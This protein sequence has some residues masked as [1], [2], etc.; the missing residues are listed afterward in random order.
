MS[1]SGPPMGVRRMFEF[2]RELRRPVRRRRAF[3]VKDGLYRRRRRSARAARP[4]NAARRGQGRRRCRRPDQR[5]RQGPPPPGG[6]GA[7]ARGGAPLR[8]RR[9]AAQGGRHGRALGR[10][11]RAGTSPSRPGP[12]P[13]EQAACALLGAGAVRRHR[14]RRRGR[15]RRP[16]GAARQRRGGPAGAGD[17]GAGARPADPRRAARP[18]TCAPPPANSTSRSPCSKA[19]AGGTQA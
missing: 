18:A 10:T 14:P 3:P 13:V 7:V 4:E 19:Q 15:D 17:A 5:P 16:R 11:F 2:G 6:R 1:P 12:R 8:R 9:A